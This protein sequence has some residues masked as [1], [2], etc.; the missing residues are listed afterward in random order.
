MPLD[1]ISLM[2]NCLPGGIERGHTKGAPPP[3][4]RVENGAPYQHAGE[5]NAPACKP[6]SGERGAASPGHG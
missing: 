3:P 6:S 2:C 1:T 4:Q 5:H